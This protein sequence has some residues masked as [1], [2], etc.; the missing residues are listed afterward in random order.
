MPEIN[1]NGCVFDVK[2]LAL[3]IFAILK[4]S[5]FPFSVTKRFER[6]TFGDPGRVLLSFLPQRR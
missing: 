1:E 2:T 6:E 5:F 4:G 3:S